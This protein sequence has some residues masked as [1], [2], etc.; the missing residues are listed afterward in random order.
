MNSNAAWA[1]DVWFLNL[2][3]QQNRFVFNPGA[4]CTLNFIPTLATMILG[5][6]AG[7]T[8]R[9]E[10][11]PPHKLCWLAVAGVITL[12]AGWGIGALGFCPVIKKLWTPSWVLFSG[13]WCLLL[14]AAFYLVLDI[15]Q[16][17]GWAFPF[18]VIGLNSIAAYGLAHLIDGFI[19]SSLLTHLGKAPFL[20]FGQPFETFLLGTASLLVLW[21]MLFWMDRRKIF[22]RI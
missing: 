22:L 8:L 10:R 19:R 3:P 20:I 5:L 21:L 4:T 14:M 12:F 2:F 9:G 11:P 18:I 7:E 6:V 13:G 16:R 1:F 15:W 17:R